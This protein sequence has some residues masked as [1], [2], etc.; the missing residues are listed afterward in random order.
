MTKNNIN[1]GRKE[2]QILGI[3]LNSTSTQKVLAFIRQKV[4]SKAK[5]YL[6]TPNPEIIEAATKDKELKKILNRADLAIPDG[7]GIL[8]FSKLKVIKGRELFL[9]VCKLAN[10]KEWKVFFIGGLKDEA[11]RTAAKLSLSLKRIKMATNPGPRLNVSGYPESRFEEEKEER[12][13]KEINAFAP[14]L[15]FVGFG[16]P[17]QEKWIARLLPE[18]KT[19][20]AM[21]VGGTFAYISGSSNLPPKI[22]NRYF[23]WLWRLITEPRRIKRIFKAVIVFPLKVLVSRFVK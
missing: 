21:T 14:E 7:I 10:K 18:L 20:G 5:F 17:K 11:Q 6:V 19:Y 12:L 9:D 15:V 3:D 13:I 23:E 4:V 22:L 8:L 2:G 16:A 1:T